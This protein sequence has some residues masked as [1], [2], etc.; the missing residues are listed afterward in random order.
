MPTC[1]RET[2]KSLEENTEINFPDLAK[3]SKTLRT[4][5]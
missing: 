2:I 5:R 3:S 1:E 4:S